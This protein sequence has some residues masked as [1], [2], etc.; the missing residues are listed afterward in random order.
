MFN[1]DKMHPYTLDLVTFICTHT[2]SYAVMN[3][4]IQE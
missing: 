1:P 3:T 2:D 4:I